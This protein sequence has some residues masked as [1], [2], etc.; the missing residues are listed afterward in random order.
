MSEISAGKPGK[1]DDHGGA[2][3]DVWREDGLRGVYEMDNAWPLQ[4]AQGE[5]TRAIVG[6]RCWLRDDAG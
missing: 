1:E 5:W 4:F 2:Y 6:R 3:L